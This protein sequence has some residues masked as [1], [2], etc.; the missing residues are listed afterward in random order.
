MIHKTE[1][2]ENAC[3]RF[4]PDEGEDA[5]Q[6]SSEDESDGSQGVRLLRD[7]LPGDGHRE[8]TETEQQETPVQ[9]FIGNKLQ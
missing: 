2:N 1:T 8:R 3:Y 9:R 5:R 4:L 6:R 7:D